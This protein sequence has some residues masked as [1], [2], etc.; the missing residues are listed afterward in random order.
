MAAR[1]T[2]SCW[3]PYPTSAYAYFQKTAIGSHSKGTRTNPLF[4]RLN[5]SVICKIQSKKEP[6][7]RELGTVRYM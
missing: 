2:S 4:V 1:L 3:F 5:P 6:D 7:F